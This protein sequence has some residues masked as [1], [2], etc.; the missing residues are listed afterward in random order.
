MLSDTLQGSTGNASNTMPRIAVR[1]RR[2]SCRTSRI[3]HARSASTRPLAHHGARK[4]ILE[5]IHVIRMRMGQ[6]NGV[7]LQPMG[8][9][10]QSAPQSI[11]TFMPRYD[12]SVTACRRWRRLRSRLPRVPMQRER[13]Q[14]TTYTAHL[15]CAGC[16]APTTRA[17]RES[18]PTARRGRP[19]PDRRVRLRSSP[20]D[21]FP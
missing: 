4:A 18:G 17:S 8:W 19:S 9:R 20:P 3:G 7:R 21:A 16:H 2:R 14:D 1:T 12:T 13:H 11:I 15:P 10:S 6:D 5:A